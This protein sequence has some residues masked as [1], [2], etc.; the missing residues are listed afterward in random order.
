MGEM[1]DLQQLSLYALLAAA[2]GRV[3]D[4]AEYCG[5]IADAG[6]DAAY[7]SMCGWAAVVAEATMK[8]DGEP[9]YWVLDV[10][11]DDGQPASLDDTD[12]DDALKA[13]ARFTTAYGNKDTD[14]C[15]AL[16][17][18][19]IKLGHAAGMMVEVLKMAAVCAPRVIGKENWAKFKADMENRR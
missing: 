3:E 8:D 14:T 19:A 12:L 2:T 5:Q 7:V 6:Y 4:T 15:V 9:G 18:A 17:K 16:Y 10:E 13:A 1:E 11:T